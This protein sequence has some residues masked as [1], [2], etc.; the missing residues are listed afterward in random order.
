[1]KKFFNP[2][3]NILVYHD[4]G[5]LLL[6]WNI[7][8]LANNRVLWMSYAEALDTGNEWAYLQYCLYF[9]VALG[10]LFSLPNIR[11]CSRFVGSYLILYIFSTTRFV[12]KVLY[13]EEFASSVDI[14]RS[15]IV[16]GVY[17]L[18]WVWIYVKMR[19]EILHKDL[20]G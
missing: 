14:G 6:F 18:L 16:T 4:Y 10:M 5:P 15:L 13:D 3:W 1:M 7:A 19:V 17:F 8:D 11:S 9:V 12:S 20:H 2:Y